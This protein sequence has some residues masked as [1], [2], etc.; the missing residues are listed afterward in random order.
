MPQKLCAL[1]HFH[2]ESIQFQKQIALSF[3]SIAMILCFVLAGFASLA[4]S[5]VPDA[6][7][8]AFRKAFMSEDGRIIDWENQEKSHSEGQ[9]YGLLLALEMDDPDT[10]DLILRWSDNNLG[11]GLRAWS[12]GNKGN[13]WGVLD[14]NNATDADVLHAWALLRAGKAWHRPDYTRQGLDIAKAV[15]GQLV[16]SPGLLL[17][18]RYGFVSPASLRL[19]LSYYVFPAFHDLAV[20]DPDRQAV[21]QRLHSKGLELVQASLANASGLP[22][23][24]IMLTPQGQMLAPKPEDAVFGYE[25]IRIPLHLAW[26]GEK[27]TLEAFRPY[28]KT[29]AAKGWMPHRPPV[30]QTP[31]FTPSASNFEAGPGHY[32]IAAKVSE[33]L[34]M[35][36][37]AKTLW[38]LAEQ[39][40]PKHQGRYYT[41]VLYL[42]A[43]ATSPSGGSI[44]EK[45]LH[46][47]LEQE[48]HQSQ[49]Q[50]EQSPLPQSPPDAAFPAP[51]SVADTVETPSKT[52]IKAAPPTQ[53]PAEPKGMTAHALKESGTAYEAPYIVPPAPVHTALSGEHAT[54]T[55]AIYPASPASDAPQTQTLA[56]TTSSR[57]IRRSGDSGTSRL[58]RLEQAAQ[59]GSEM[60]HFTATA[61]YLNA[62]RARTPSQTGSDY[63]GL[64]RQ[65]LLTE[66]TVFMPQMFAR[67]GDFSLMLG[68]TPLGGE[69]SPLPIGSLQYEG[70]GY[71]VQLFQQPVTDSL[72][73]YVGFTDI[74]SGK[75]MGRVLQSGAKLN[76]NQTFG[77]GW[78]YGGALSGAHLHGKHVKGN[79]AVK[80]ELYFGRYM[81]NGWA[82]GLYHSLDHFAT[83]LNHFTYG[84]GGYFSPYLAAAAVA[85]TSWSYET[86]NTAFKADISAGHAYSRTQDSKRFYGIQESG[87]AYTGEHNNDFTINT[88]L[89]GS[90]VL[91]ERCTLS[92][93]GRFLNAGSFTESTA[94]L[95]LRWDF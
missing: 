80:N 31:D 2:I 34:G 21:W 36:Q 64:P 41:T 51:A 4:Y 11:Q 76:W 1:T 27:K 42:L 22:P 39:S 55:T 70:T 49:A 47:D 24:W 89:E 72:L 43:R 19:N 10:F 88:G 50:G 16:I 73:S 30:N 18:A 8:Q 48:T 63:L 81:G 20:F 12:W 23:D 14:S 26:A 67:Q 7:W 75:T 37:Q 15:A 33:V 52:D 94:E 78:F 65:S 9:A 46:T 66:T 83:D 77:Q 35:K 79:N 32:A 40:R 45:S 87:P 29:I 91:M 59:F 85:F 60:L 44:P 54:L 62:S 57:F 90:L 58:L 17:P 6:E 86:G 74:Y 71:S 69:V 3:V 68:T 82:L 28:L 25:A 38:R 61:I 56:A 13:T 84:H 95:S 5:R 93:A 53:L 92:L